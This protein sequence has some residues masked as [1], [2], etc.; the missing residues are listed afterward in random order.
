[1]LTEV[2]ARWNS[3]PENQDLTGA[4]FTP[5]SI[6]FKKTTCDGDYEKICNNSAITGRISSCNGDYGNNGWKGLATV[7]IRDN[8][9]FK[10]ISKVNEFY[11][12]DNSA[13]QHVLCQ[14]IGH[15]MPMG[16]QSE[17][18]SDQNSCMDYSIL[19]PN[20]SANWYPN[21]HDVE[22]LDSIYNT[23]RNSPT[24]SPTTMALP[25]ATPTA[26]PSLTG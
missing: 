25:T 14:E 19:D 23:C 10:A 22:L 1:M 13:T 8:I 4:T 12:M 24:F 26:A 2:V 18:G 16:H 9:I 11:K 6:S 21:K 7:L 20:N 3:V 5:H 15:G 17:D